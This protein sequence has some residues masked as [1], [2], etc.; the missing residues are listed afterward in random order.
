MRLINRRVLA[1]VAYLSSAPWS[2]SGRRGRRAIPRRPAPGSSIR[3]VHYMP[4][5]APKEQ[6]DH[7]GHAGDTL[8]CLEGNRRK[9]KPNTTNYT[10]TFDGKDN[11]IKGRRCT[12][13][14]AQTI[15]A[16]TTEQTRRKR[17]DRPDAT[18]TISA[19]GK[20][21]TV[22]SVGKTA[23]GKELHTWRL[24]EKQ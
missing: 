14:V 4:G 3:Q 24:Y 17:A 18:R 21:M 2:S 11:P 19:D 16:N 13:R 12:T 5:A 9:N 22:T 10:A 15:D 8:R 1:S 23:D 6:R 20:T 7:D